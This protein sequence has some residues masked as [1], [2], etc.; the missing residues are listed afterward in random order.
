MAPLTLPSEADALSVEKL[1]V[2]FGGQLALADFDFRVAPGEIHALIGHNGSGKSTAIRVLAGAVMPAAGRMSVGGQPVATGSPRASLRAG[3]RFVHQDL[4][5]VEGL[6]AIDNVALA[7]G[8]DRGTAGL[9]RWRQLRRR[10]EADLATFGFGGDPRVAVSALD[11]FDR[12]I[13]ALVRAVGYVDS[14][15][16]VVALDEITAAL[17]EV[18]VKRL[19]ALTRTLARRGISVIYV[20][21][22]LDEVITIADR[23]TV[24]RNGGVAGDALP[25]AGQT[26]QSLVELMFGGAEQPAAPRVRADPLAGEPAAGEP[27]AGEPAAAAPAPQRPG[28]RFTQVTADRLNAITLEAFPGEVV[29]VYGL[30][31]SGREELAGVL[32]GSDGAATLSV[33]AAAGF[34]LTLARGRRAGL[35]LVPRDRQRNGALPLAPVRENLGLGAA[36]G[37]N[38][39]W[40][41]TRGTERR[42]AQQ[43]LRLV[44]LGD[45]DTD[46]PFASYSGGMQ[47]RVLIARAMA[48][49]PRV[50]VL[51][52]P[53]QGVDVA[54]RAAIHG[55]ITRACRD[56]GLAAIVI[57]SDADELAAIADR[58]VVLRGGAVAASLTGAELTQQRIVQLASAA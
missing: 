22:Y 17:P 44:G 58:V 57:S 3:L 39:R 19:L 25:A 35:A 36:A 49:K 45:A 43:A 47:Q 9:I 54:A 32:A 42:Y 23:V 11:P 18:E 55:L 46:L 7:N 12:L 21:H 34:A 4:R 30:D 40:F 16:R 15:V 24:L 53:S 2:D 13:V 38:S 48:M 50:L 51:D 1:T 28:Y 52:E 31:G 41:I 37:G 5:L 56:R 14:A 27:A 20:S 6:D 29:G 8:Y 33:N 10:T 26:A